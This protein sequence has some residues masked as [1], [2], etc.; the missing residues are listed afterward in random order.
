MSGSAWSNQVVSRVI[1]AGTVGQELVYDQAPPAFG[2]LIGSILGAN[3]TDPY[4]NLGLSGITAYGNIS[5]PAIHFIAV[6]MTTNGLY[7]STSTTEAGPWTQI[8][9]VIYF[10]SLSHSTANTGLL[11]SNDVSAAKLLLTD[12][13]DAAGKG[14]IVALNSFTYPNDPNATQAVETWH[15]ITLD[16]GWSAGTQAPQYRLT[17]A[18]DVQLRGVATHASFT[19]N[20]MVNSG[21]PLPT[22]YRPGVVR[23]YRGADP[24]SS[25]GMPQMDPTGILSIRAT[26]SFPATQGI[27]DGF[28]SI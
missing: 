11:L 10:E 25:C 16:A 4:G 28:Y 7:I 17:A 20:T 8:A 2:H 27:I 13:N 23:F 3:F 6:E 9:R 22:A 5:I 21:T 1:I 14:R 26:A 15:N 18:G 19:G 12:G 24:A